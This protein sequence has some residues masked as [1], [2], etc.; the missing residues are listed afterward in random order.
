MG[1][2][3][4]WLVL[5]VAILAASYLIEGIHVAGFFSAFFAAAVLG[6][7]NAF[8][9]PVLI[10]LTLPVNVLTFGL[11]TFI[12][13]AVLLL[14][15]SGVISGFEV[16]GFWTAV[17][18]SLVVSIVSWLLNVFIG[19]GGR[20]ERIDTIDLRKGRGGRWE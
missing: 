20:V 12:I 2:V 16:R 13:N 7:L 3:L 1:L 6:V 14:M 18:G 17:F 9:R 19:R 8:L 10:L 11:F 4:R 15:V 5:T